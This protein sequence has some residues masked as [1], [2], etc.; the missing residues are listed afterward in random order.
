MELIGEDNEGTY[1]YKVILIEVGTVKTLR[2]GIQSD[3]D[4]FEGLLGQASSENGIRA[5]IKN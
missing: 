5:E 4:N 1:K 3:W 2:N